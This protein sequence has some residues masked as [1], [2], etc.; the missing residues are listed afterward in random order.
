MIVDKAVEFK[1][2]K[3]DWS[4]GLYCVGCG[5]R[6]LFGHSAF[7]IGQEAYGKECLAK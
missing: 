3:K 2:E 7:W 1:V 6:I 5:K 4:E